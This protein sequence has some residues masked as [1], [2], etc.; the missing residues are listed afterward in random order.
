MDG[1]KVITATYDFIRWVIPHIA[2]FPRNQRYTLGERVENKV[3]SLL[4][5]LIQAQYAK[6]KVDILSKSNLEIEQLRYLFRLCHDLRLI[7]L[8]TYELSSKYLV[9]IGSQV[10]AWLKYRSG[11]E[12]TS[13]PF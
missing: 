12:K 7:N 11:H 10:G 9:D 5:L 13:S 8:K 4:E 1:P 2:K 3:I 6:E